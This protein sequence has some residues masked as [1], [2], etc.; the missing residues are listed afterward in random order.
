M[1]NLTALI[2][3]LLLLS[4]NKK[5]ESKSYAV[6]SGTVRNNSEDKITVRNFENNVVAQILID[7]NGNFADTIAGISLGF[8]R[9][10][11]GNESSSIFLKPGYELQLNI[12]PEQFDES[13]QYQGLG[14]QENNYLAKKF[15]LEES[16][17]EILGY[18]YLGSL[19]EDGFM[20]KMDSIKGVQENL[21]MN[22]AGLDPD[23]QMIEKGN[24][25]YAWANKMI[26]YQAYRRYVLEDN[27]FNVSPDFNNYLQELNLENEQL[28]DL[29]NYRNFLQKYYSNK[30][31]AGV[32]DDQDMT[33]D[34]LKIISREVKSQKIKNN[35]LYADAKYGVTY[36]NSLQEYYDCFMANSTNEDH[37]K[38]ITE[39]Y[40]KLMLVAPGRPSPPFDDYE[41][42][43]GGKTSLDDLKGNYVYVDVWATWCGPCKREIPKLKEITKAYDGKNIKFVSISIDKQ[44]DY[45]TWK[46]MVGDENLQG[47]QLFAPQD[48]NSKF[49]TDYSILGIPRFI[50]IDP[51]GNIVNANAPRP[52]SKELPELLESLAI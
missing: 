48:W 9:F 25:L 35:L 28:S 39:R 18:K 34:L 10:S 30:A 37:K 32:S 19:E 52:T 43:A 26:N 42:Y 4:C 31:F 38:E 16:L 8:Y 47:I 7:P 51:A 13:I 49:V 15:L 33:V 11:I 2:C 21:L 44:K 5:E 24:I 50:L 29:S 40:E 36:T 41:N 23:F 20:K 3:V 27:E 14:A 46:D 17:Q 22:E 1:K 12:D 6:F 45:D